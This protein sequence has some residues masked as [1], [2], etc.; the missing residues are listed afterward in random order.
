MLN[1]R[2]PDPVELPHPVHT[3]GSAHA[4]PSSRARCGSLRFPASAV[5]LGF[6]L[7]ALPVQAIEFGQ[8]E[9]QGSLDTTISHGITWRVGARDEGRVGNFLSA[10]SND[11]NLNY[12]R[13]IVSNTSKFTTDLDL[14]YRNFGAFVR[15]TGFIDFENENGMRDRT[16]LSAEARDLVGQELDLLDAYVTGAFDVGDAAVDLRV[17]RQVLNWGESTFITNGVNAFNRFDVSKLRLPGSELREALA[18]I[19]MVSLSVAPT[20]NLSMEG[21]YQ[22]DWEETVID[23]VGS[24]FS[25]T[26]YVGAGARE[27]V[28]VDPVFEPLLGP[29]G[30]DVDRSFGF[31]PLTAG[32]INHDLAELHGNASSAGIHQCTAAAPA[33]CRSRF[34]DRVARSGPRSRRLGP[35]GTGHALSRGRT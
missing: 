17:G 32:A 21:F 34:R 20:Y 3:G 1:L 30:S 12:D 14:A 24:F 2:E 6:A 18:P 19:P 15:A 27:A 28:I 11:G 22:L 13:G 29:V 7:H 33:G 10:N 31:G 4:P 5:V 16:P 26:D 9:V 35:V 23:P 8:G 25:T